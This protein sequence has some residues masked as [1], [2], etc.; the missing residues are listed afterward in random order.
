MIMVARNRYRGVAARGAMLFFLLN[1][2]NKIHAF[3]QF[4]LNA[5]VAVFARGIDNAPFGR[6]KKGVA[7][8]EEVA[9]DT[10]GGDAAPTDTGEGDGG[11]RANADALLVEGKAAADDAA[12]DEAKEEEDEEEDYSMSPEDLERRLVALTECAT[13]TVFDFTRRG[14]FDRDKLI[15][16]SLLTFTI[17]LRSKMIDV[18]EHTA[19]VEGKKNPTPQPAPNDLSR[20]IA[21]GQ[22]GALD[23][24]C[25]TVPVFTNM[26]KEMDKNSDDW[27]KYCGHERPEDAKMPGEWGKV[28]TSHDAEIKRRFRELLIIRAL[29]PDRITNALNK[30]CSFVM[31]TEYV[32]QPAF[33]FEAMMPE[34]TFQTPLFFILFPGYS[35][36]KDLEKYANKVGY[37]VDAGNL[38]LISMGQGQEK[39]AEATLDKYMQEG[40]W[41]FLDNVHLMQARS[42]GLEAGWSAASF[43]HVWIVTQL[44]EHSLDQQ[45]NQSMDQVGPGGLHIQGCGA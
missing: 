28:V 10:A 35:P 5:F 8:V 14:L 6:K 29:R 16:T 9:A 19:L 1:S 3:Y 37:S 44:P 13:F 38:T 30:F 25:S 17:L 24:L 27:E 21:E 22:W 36:S 11:E 23:V 15:I 45:K 4:S 31:G 12:D 18:V 34:S 7:A 33:T 26:A 43:I 42:L 39:P 20:W 40:G 32:N 2:L 41:V